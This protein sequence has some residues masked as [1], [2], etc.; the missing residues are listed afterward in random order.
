[1]VAG[2]VR[3]PRMSAFEVTTSDGVKLHSK[4]VSDQGIIETIII[5]PHS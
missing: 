4:L 1:V 2:N 3:P 5:A